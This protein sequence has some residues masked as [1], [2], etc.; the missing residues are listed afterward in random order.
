MLPVKLAIWWRSRSCVAG[1]KRDGGYPQTYQQML[2]INLVPH[3][4]VIE[5]WLFIPASGQPRHEKNSN[6]FKR[7]S[8]NLIDKKTNGTTQDHDIE[9]YTDFTLHVGAWSDVKKIEI[10]NGFFFE[11]NT[12]A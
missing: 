6:L 4:G 10:L 3:F 8:N 12:L 1:A 9:T 2:G 5:V 11:L 7:F